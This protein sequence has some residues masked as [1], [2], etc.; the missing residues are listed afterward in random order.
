VAE[1]GTI[2]EDPYA[3]MA[4]HPKTET[5]EALP[6][7]V[8]IGLRK[9]HDNLLA[10]NAEER[11]KRHAARDLQVCKRLLQVA[12]VFLVILICNSAFGTWFMTSVREAP[13]RVIC[14][15]PLIHHC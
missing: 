5:F 6:S 13:A 9:A 8:D 4:H 3:R 11:R 15:V 7:G 1:G 2:R 10:A 12:I 14:T